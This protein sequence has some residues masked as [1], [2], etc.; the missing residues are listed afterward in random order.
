ML[1]DVEADEEEVGESSSAQAP[2]NDG[3][4]SAVPT[5]GKNEAALQ[6]LAD[7]VAALRTALEKAEFQC[8]SLKV[9]NG[10]LSSRLEGQSIEAE[11]REKDLCASVKRVSM[12]EFDLADARR[13]IKG[14]DVI[15]ADLTKKLEDVGKEQG[16]T[17][18]SQAA[19]SSLCS[20]LQEDVN[21]LRK[22]RSEQAEKHEAIVAE[23]KSEVLAEADKVSHLQ[24]LLKEQ[25]ER[26]KRLEE[27][28]ETANRD[29]LLSG[30]RVTD[31][32]VTPTPKSPGGMAKLGKAFTGLFSFDDDEEGAAKGEGE[33]GNLSIRSRSA[34]END[35]KE[36]EEDDMFGNMVGFLTSRRKT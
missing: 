34:S 6:E 21:L 29:L 36:E 13:D 14:R 28:L 9:E 32:E 23:A 27:E 16:E 24:N 17:G 3:Q 11:S 33:G 20:T 19:E 10:E 1:P 7:E 15:I 8:S 31:E 18:G 26:N 12:L 2:V 4:D 22:Q 5:E 30:G 35:L 25:Q